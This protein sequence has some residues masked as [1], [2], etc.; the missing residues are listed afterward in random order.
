MKFKAILSPKLSPK[1]M[2]KL[3][4]RP[5]PKVKAKA[6]AKPKVALIAKLK[7]KRKEK[8]RSK[9]MLMLILRQALRPRASSLIRSRRS[10]KVWLRE[11]QEGRP[12]HQV[13]KR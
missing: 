1:P 9:P 5:G 6:R 3:A 11:L 8:A 7:V 2:L 4:P 13:P 10:V 12:A